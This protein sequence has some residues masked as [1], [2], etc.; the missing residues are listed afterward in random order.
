MSRPQVIVVIWSFTLEGDIEPKVLLSLDCFAVAL[1]VV[2]VSSGLISKGWRFFD[3]LGG[4]I[5]F[6]IVVISLLAIGLYF[7]FTAD[8]DQDMWRSG[9]L[10]DRSSEVGLTFSHSLKLIRAGESFVVHGDE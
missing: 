7:G 3:D 10:E 9:K 1:L 5:D 2:E 4:K 8:K 6:A